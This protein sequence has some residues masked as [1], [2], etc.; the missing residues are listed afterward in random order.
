[1]SVP[2]PAS[3]RSG[4]MQAV[5]AMIAAYVAV[6]A[7]IGFVKYSH[8][9]Y[10]DFDLAI[11]AQACDR[12][13]HGSLH[14]S[15]RGMNWLGDHSSLVL[16]LVAPLYGLFHDPRA[17]LAVQTVAL[18]LGALPVHALALRELGDRRAALGCAA[19][20]LLY[21]ALGYANLFEFH[22]ETLSTAPLLAAFYF[23]RA[24]RLGPAAG[25]AALALLGKEDVALAVL[26]LAVYALLQPHPARWRAAATLGVLGLASLGLSFAILKPMLGGPE[27]EYGRMYAAWGATT[28]EALRAMATHPLR[29]V[30]MLV[31]T[32]GD[33]IDSTLKSQYFLHLLMPL[34][35]LPFAS[36]ATLAIAAPIVAEHM[37]SSRTQQH[38]ILYQYTAAVTPFVIAAAVLGM[39]RL[40]RWVEP[41]RLV[42]FAL[43]AS[44]VCN[45]MFGPIAGHGM[46]QSRRA[47]QRVWPDADDR[48]A[49]HAARAMLAQ[50][51]AGGVVAGFGLL[52]AV[53]GRDSVHSFHHVMSGTYTYSSRPYPLPEGITAVIVNQGGERLLPAVDS[54][55]GRRLRRLIEA[56]DV[57]PVE[58][59]GDLV[60][61]LRDPPAPIPL[62]VPS[63][64]GIPPAP[65]IVYDRQ[66]ELLGAEVPDSA[67]AG[68][69]LRFITRWRRVAPVDRL[70]MTQWMLI[71]AAGTP[72]LSRLRY[73]GY[74]ENPPG[75]WPEG[76]PM[77]EEYRLPIPGSLPPGAYRLAVR[78]GWRREGRVRLA[79]A[80]DSTLAGREMI[81]PL[82]AVRI[83]P[84]PGDGARR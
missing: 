84:G 53:S 22:P 57:A 31:A 61:Y 14:S 60:L 5:W 82:G 25:W 23:V 72:A 30:S 66:L 67:I 56:N 69:R 71:D 7:T 52:P 26:G 54:G 77:R 2:T 34:G 58:S 49:A 76:A 55:T 43:V 21:P 62:C 1:M 79:S 44:L 24:G 64:E 15:I 68:D 29:A 81:V 6:Y 78:L 28:G 83:A 47:L 27:A 38:S 73:L 75:D 33:P 36:P 65:G 80:S 16:F 39:R 3:P 50:V 18:A 40:A 35:F 20:Y 32:P 46:Q 8:M 63:P 41:L 11:F 13:L 51:P 4:A 37:L 59:A 70:F 48:A 74:L 10:D 17:L 9:L 12:L 45:W 42:G 19:V